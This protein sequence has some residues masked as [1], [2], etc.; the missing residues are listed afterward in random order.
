MKTIP[1]AQRDMRE[2]VKDVDGGEFTDIQLAENIESCRVEKKRY[3]DAEK[4]YI[5]ELAQRMLERVDKGEIQP[6]ENG[7]LELELGEGETARRI[8]VS[9]KHL[10]D[11]D[12]NQLAKLRTCAS[13]EKIFLVFSQM[14]SGKQLKAL[15]DVVGAAA[16][17]IIDAAKRDNETDVWVLKIKKPKKVKTGRGRGRRRF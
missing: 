10:K 3:S 8:V 17:S 13:D 11:Y 5:K 12:Q 1:A 2:I 9:H 6:N 4:R 7:I 16:K 15:S 14:P